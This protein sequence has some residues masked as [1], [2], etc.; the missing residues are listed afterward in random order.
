MRSC[1][2]QSFLS[3]FGMVKLSFNLTKSCVV[4]GLAAILLIGG[5][6]QSG[7]QPQ[8]SESARDKDPVQNKGNVIVSDG[9]ITIENG[10]ITYGRPVVT[11]EVEK[12]IYKSLSFFRN[13][14]R[15]IE[16]KNPGGN[17]GSRQSWD[18]YEM[19]RKAFVFKYGIS[20]A[21]MDSILKRGDD[22]E[23]K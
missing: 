20:D 8:S 3:G 22:Q 17:R 4:F 6:G 9:P 5:C 14:A 1:E 2:L 10:K 7:E 15:S 23:W 21:D 12:E 16:E 18:D 19:A 13:L 11:E